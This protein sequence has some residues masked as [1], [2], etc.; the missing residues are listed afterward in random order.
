MGLIWA[1]LVAQSV[2]NLPAVQHSGFNPWSRSKCN[3]L[4]HSCLENLV[5]RG[6]WLAT[7]HDVYGNLK[8]IDNFTILYV[9]IITHR[10]FSNY[11][12]LIYF[13]NLEV[14]STEVLQILSKNYF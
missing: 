11:A 8:R 4:Q 7:V 3:P 10:Y 2:K 6:A 1:S 12:V 14:F 13:G 5:D 9:L